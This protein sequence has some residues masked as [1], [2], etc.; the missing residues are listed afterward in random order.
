MKKLSIVVALSLSLTSC[1]KLPAIVM[2]VAS[3]A[4]APLAAVWQGIYD[5]VKTLLTGGSVDWQTQLSKLES[6]QGTDAVIC[7]VNAVV[8]DLSRTV[9]SATV[10]TVDRTAAIARGRLYLTSKH[11]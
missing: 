11:K 4:L 8:L 5:D 3:C 7:A 9:M 1:V 10:S 6:Q 2:D